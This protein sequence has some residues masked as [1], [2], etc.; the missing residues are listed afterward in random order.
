MLVVAFLTLILGP[1]MTNA[2]TCRDEE[3]PCE[4]Y[5]QAGVV[6]VGRVLSSKCIGEIMPLTEYEIQVR[7]VYAGNLGTMVF[8]ESYSDACGYNFRV[9]EEYLIY[10]GHAG[11]ESL[12]V[13]R[14]AATRCSRTRSLT[15]ASADLKFL[16][17]DLNKMGGSRIYGWIKEDLSLSRDIPFEK[18]TPPIEG[19]ALKVIGPDR[20]YELT[21]DSKGEYSLTGLTSGKYFIELI[22]TTAFYTERWEREEFYVNPN[23]CSARNFCLSRN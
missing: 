7:K 21:T 18:R 22:S 3:N 12:P 23:G 14:F 1:I 15:E 9:G 11:N 6:F 20:T 17:K 5:G 16:R 8:A 19:Y 10:G 4:A 2:C 13:R